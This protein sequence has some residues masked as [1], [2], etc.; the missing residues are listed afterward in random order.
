MPIKFMEAP[1]QD[2]RDGQY[3][4]LWVGYA[5]LQHIFATAVADQSFIAESF[6]RVPELMYMY[7]TM[8]FCSLL[9]IGTP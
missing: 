9:C 2:F 6:V 7:G 5:F 8:L 3:H 4:G 1:P